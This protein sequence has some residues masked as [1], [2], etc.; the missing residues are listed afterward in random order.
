[1]QVTGYD[2]CKTALRKSGAFGTGQTPLSEDIN[3]AFTD[4]K[5]MIALWQRKRW[6]VFHLVD[7]AFT[8][9]G[10]LSYT[11]GP[12]GNFPMTSRPDK[13]DSAFIRLNPTSALAVDFPLAFI[14]SREDYNDIG[15]KN[16]GSFPS[17]IYYDGAYPLGNAFVYPVPS[18]G[19][20]EIHLTVKDLLAPNLALTADINLP[21]EYYEALVYNLAGRLRPSYQLPPDPVINALA[22]AAL[23]TIKGANAQIPTLGMPAGVSRGGSGYN[24]FSDQ[25]G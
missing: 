20:Y 18:A 19:T 12:S 13:I 23:N 7:M 21:D 6:N 4:L 14:S 10:A 11:V 15:I 2:L 17:A 24:I 1:M 22:S 25:G 16:L 5:F 8:S 3:D 9:T